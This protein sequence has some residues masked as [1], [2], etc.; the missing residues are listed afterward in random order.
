M[1]L[2]KRECDNE[3]KHLGYPFLVSRNLFSSFGYLKKRY[4]I[5]LKGGWLELGREHRYILHV[6]G[7]SSSNTSFLEKVLGV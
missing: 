5:G 7:S 1:R 2:G 3:V 4:L 6:G